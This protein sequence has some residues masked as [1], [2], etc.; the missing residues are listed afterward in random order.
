[1]LTYLRDL[2][3]PTE[4]MTSNQTHVKLSLLQ[5]SRENL[6]MPAPSP[7]G[8]SLDVFDELATTKRQCRHLL[9]RLFRVV[10]LPLPFLPFLLSVSPPCFLPHTPCFSSFPPLERPMEEGEVGGQVAT[11]CT[12]RLKDRGGERSLSDS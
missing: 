1:M 9:R 6:A 5:H 3:E 11:P 4:E 7:R 10:S 12:I 8:V 2:P